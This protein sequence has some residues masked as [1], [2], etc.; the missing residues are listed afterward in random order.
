MK[1]IIIIDANSATV[2]IYNLPKKLE[3]AQS[4]EIEEAYEING[5]S[6][7]IYGDILISNYTG[8]KIPLNKLLK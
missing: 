5:D 8:E 7:Y 4:E 2:E 6:E 3:N 1:K